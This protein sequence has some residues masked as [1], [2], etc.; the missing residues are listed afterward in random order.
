VAF[1]P[2][3]YVAFGLGL[4]AGWIVRPEGPWVARATIATIVVLVGLLGASLVSI[5]PIA[6]L[7]TIPLALAFA[8]LV[9]GL[10]VLVVVLIA[11]LRPYAGAPTVPG[12]APERLPLSLLLL[13]AL[14]SG[15]GVGRAVPL[16]AAAAIPWALCALLAVVGFGLRLRSG[17]LPSVWRPL[18]A[19]TVGAAAAALVFGLATR[20]AL[21]VAF[22][23]AGGFGFYSLAGPLV[24]ARAGAVLG[25]L[26]F[27]TN[28]LREDLT[29]LTAPLLGR[30]LRGEGLTAMGGA[31][32]MDTTLYFVTR[33]GD[34]DAGSLAIASGLVLT[35]VASL[36]LPALLA[37]PL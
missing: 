29:M 15:Y 7:T 27:L 33:Y 8:A 12:A 20:T 5:A 25:L 16:P 11:R 37:L 22:A 19:A 13:L 23:T 28:F 6:L 34:R 24:A 36:L 32:S 9:L 4:L 35:I 30:R 14:A 1:D 2:Y 31:T 10:T 17:R 26:A 18:L 21:P 3:L